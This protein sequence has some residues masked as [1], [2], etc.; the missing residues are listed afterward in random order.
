[1]QK[2]KANQYEFNIGQRV[3]LEGDSKYELVIR[4]RRVNSWQG[5]QQD[6]GSRPIY[7]SNVYSD[8]GSA[9]YQENSLQEAK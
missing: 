6:D 5:A 2:T 4:F 8:N 1:M 3:W 7:Y 9:W